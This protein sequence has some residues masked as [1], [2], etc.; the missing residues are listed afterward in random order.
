VYNCIF[1]FGGY[2]GLCYFVEYLVLY[3]FVE[4]MR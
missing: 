2:V 4:E 1:W 3:Y